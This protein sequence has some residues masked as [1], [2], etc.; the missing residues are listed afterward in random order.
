MEEEKEE[1]EE[2]KQQEEKEEEEEEVEILPRILSS[3]R[4]GRHK[5]SIR[6]VVE[7]S[8]LKERRGNICVWSLSLSFS[9]HLLQV[10]WLFR[11]GGRRQ[12]VHTD[13]RPMFSNKWPLFSKNVPGGNNSLKKRQLPRKFSS[14]KK[15]QTNVSGC[16]VL[17]LSLN[18]SSYVRHQL[19]KKKSLR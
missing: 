18:S 14:K 1:E 17:K 3:R 6:C 16:L 12:R 7:V 13:L 11:A 8:G 4:G 10:C 15:K 5:C 2:E 19:Y 9:L